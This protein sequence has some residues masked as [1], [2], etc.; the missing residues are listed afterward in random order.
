MNIPT[1]SQKNGG[2]ENVYK[3]WKENKQFW[4]T[5]TIEEDLAIHAKIKKAFKFYGTK[6][7]VVQ[8]LSKK[9]EVSTETVAMWVEKALNFQ[10]LTYSELLMRDFH[11]LILIERISDV[12]RK[13][14]KADD[15]AAMNA[16]NAQYAN[17]I[18]KFF[19]TN[20]LIDL[21]KLII[22]KQ[23]LSFHPEIA[24]DLP[25]YDSAEFN[26]LL[27]S[28]RQWKKKSTRYTDFT[29]VK[30]DGRDS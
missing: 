2:V 17:A 3:L 1:I 7:A 27:A 5:E 13:A 9:E 15:L 11:V 21:S 22:V 26:T 24:K 23:E 25:E 19:G 4:I 30:E 10:M 14:E 29:E 6:Y 12:Y 20:A 18:E 28:L 16:S 8:H